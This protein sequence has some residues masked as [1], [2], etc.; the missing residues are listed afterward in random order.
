VL[1]ARSITVSVQCQESGVLE[2][3][4]AI[5]EDVQRDN[6]GEGHALPVNLTRMQR[7][8]HCIR[9]VTFASKTDR[10][11]L[12]LERCRLGT[13][14]RKGSGSCYSIGDSVS[15][16][17][18]RVRVSPL[19]P[20]L[21]A[22]TCSITRSQLDVDSKPSHPSLSVIERLFLQTNGNIGTLR[23]P[24]ERIAALVRSIMDVLGLSD[25]KH[26][27]STRSPAPYMTITQCL[28]TYISPKQPASSHKDGGAVP[29]TFSTRANGV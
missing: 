13:D 19:S 16:V 23:P 11:I 10:Y 2:A 8:G 22:S 17:R 21:R 3:V 14:W 12:G 6:L 5:P 15:T 9:N 27:K 20:L 29:F 1:T 28:R 4:A 18:A 25:S 7:Q 26:T 24:P